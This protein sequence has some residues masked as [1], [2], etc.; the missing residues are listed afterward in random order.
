MNN[1][2]TSDTDSALAWLRERRLAKEAVAR[3]EYAKAFTK[4]RE[5]SATNR[6]E[7]LA[8]FAQ[9]DQMLADV[10]HKLDVIEKSRAP[11]SIQ[12]PRRELTSWSPERLAAAL[13]DI[14]AAELEKL[15]Q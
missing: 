2:A 15:L 8:K 12:P 9:I 1:S 3:E 4:Q 10:L 5:Q 6:R 11:L 13:L 7:M 14:P